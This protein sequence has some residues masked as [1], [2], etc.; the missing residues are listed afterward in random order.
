LVSLFAEV[1][2]NVHS[3]VMILLFL[4]M[5]HAPL[6]RTCITLYSYVELQ[7]KYLEYKG[8]QGTINVTMR[9]AHPSSWD[10]HNYEAKAALIG[11]KRQ[12]YSSVLSCYQSKRLTNTI[13]FSD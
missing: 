6:M 2:R 1:Q 7:Q 4:V 9:F 5:S 3:D 11:G 13:F 8:F 10:V 12:Q